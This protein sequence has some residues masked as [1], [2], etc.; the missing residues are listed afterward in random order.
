MDTQKI[1]SFNIIG[2][3]VRTTNENSQAAKDI[4]ALWNK[5]M[6]ENM[7]QQIPNKVDN[8]IYCMYTEYEKDHTKPYTTLL[9]CK[10]ESLENIPTGMIGKTVEGGNYIKQTVKGNLM[11]GVIATAWIKIWNA[12]FSRLYTADFEVYGEKAQN[13]ENA[14]VDIFIAVK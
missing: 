5:F 2:I 9:G 1:T 3:A 12:N 11:Q 10:V 13:P 4:P 6:S 14:E 7:L 8:T